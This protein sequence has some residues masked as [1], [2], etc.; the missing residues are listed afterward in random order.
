MKSQMTIG[1]KLTLGFSASLLITLIFGGLMLNVV[2]SLR[3]NMEH[4]VTVTARK[5]DLAAQMDAAVARMRTNVR[6]V[7]LAAALKDPAGMAKDQKEFQAKSAEFRKTLAEMRPLLLLERGKQAAN[8]LEASMNEWTPLM[9][10]MVELC[11]QGKLEEANALRIGKQLE[12]VNQITAATEELQQIQHELMA[13]DYQS[14]Q[15]DAS[16]SR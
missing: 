3:D 15:T 8:R 5:V 6:G 2:A 13:G 1:K 10:Q 11:K 14:A 4:T 16:R 7:A 12:I 9:D